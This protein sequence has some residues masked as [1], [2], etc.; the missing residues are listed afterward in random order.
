MRWHKTKVGGSIE[1]I[2]NFTGTRLLSFLIRFF[3]VIKH[4]E[5]QN[6]GWELFGVITVNKS[7]QSVAKVTRASTIRLQ[8][9]LQIEAHS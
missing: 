5:N 4:T 2:A 6:P 9:T 1:E 3:L 7:Y 8:S